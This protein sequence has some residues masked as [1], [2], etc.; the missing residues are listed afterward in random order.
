MTYDMVAECNHPSS[1]EP[2]PNVVEGEEDDVAAVTKLI[3]GISK[4]ETSHSMNHVNACN[5]K[6]PDTS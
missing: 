1:L 4:S 2:I 6:C 5:V 3:A